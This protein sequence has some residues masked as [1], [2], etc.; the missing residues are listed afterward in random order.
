MR[1]GPAVDVACAACGAPC[2]AVW[3]A[4]ASL[5]GAPTPPR[6]RLDSRR[7]CPP[8]GVCGE[9][10]VG[11]AARRLRRTC[12][13]H[14]RHNGRHAKRRGKANIHEKERQTHRRNR[15]RSVAKSRLHRSRTRLAVNVLQIRDVAGHRF[16]LVHLPACV[17]IVQACARSQAANT[18]KQAGWVARQVVLRAHQTISPLTHARSGGQEKLLSMICW[19]VRDRLTPTLRAV[20][21]VYVR[22]EASAARWACS[23]A[24]L[25]H[26]APSALCTAAV[27]P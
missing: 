4:P 15:A 20:V 5:L 9:R 8:H 26:S 17:A 22:C 1:H 19:L 2:I 10:P 27:R 7:W 14:G 25:C 18:S 23:G 11:R 6:S 13:R 3:P 16:Q 12:E 21:W 24:L